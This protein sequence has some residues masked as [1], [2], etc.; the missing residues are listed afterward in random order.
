MSTLQHACAV[1]TD[2]LVL[3]LSHDQHTNMS[4]E[5]FRS[6]SKLTC[7]RQLSLTNLESLRDEHLPALLRL[8]QLTYLDLSR[9]VHVTTAG[10]RQLEVLPLVWLHCW[11]CRHIV[12]QD[13]PQKLQ[14]AVCRVKS[15]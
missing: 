14:L 1:F 8:T 13:L 12:T 2:L 9:C 5:G 6:L 10:V 11:A 4:G 7:L 3:E 15:V